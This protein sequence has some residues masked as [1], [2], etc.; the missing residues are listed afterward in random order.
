ML[1]GKLVR[2]RAL[3]P[4]DAQHA[5]KWINDREVTQFLG[6]RYPYSLAFE[7]NWA[8]EA[9]KQ[10]GFTELRLLIETKDGQAIGVCGLHRGSPEDRNA[11]VG[12]M[13][14]EKSF[15]SSGYGTD[16]MV[17]LMRF[18]FHQMNLHRIDLGVFEF[19][20]RAQACYRKCGFTEEGRRRE[21]YYQDGR[22]WDVV[23][24]GILRHEFDATHG[25]EQAEAVETPG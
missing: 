22:Y 14:G 5:H 15:W 1:E 13:L 21:A 11:E 16:A 3:E 2:L 23:R 10:N 19:N 12:I 20:A 9:A 18:G 6:A 24:M 25:V 4:A 7:V 8:T 17:T